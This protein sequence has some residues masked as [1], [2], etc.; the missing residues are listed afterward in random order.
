MDAPQPVVTTV[1]DDIHAAIDRLS[2]MGKR[3]VAPT[4]HGYRAEDIFR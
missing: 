2:D 4:A 1:V 3:A